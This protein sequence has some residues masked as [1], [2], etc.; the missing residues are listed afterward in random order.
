MYFTRIEFFK[1]IYAS[2]IDNKINLTKKLNKVLENMILK[3]P[4]HWIWTHNRWK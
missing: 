4:N 3:N 2:N 1:E